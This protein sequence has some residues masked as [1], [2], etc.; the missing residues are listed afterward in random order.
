RLEGL[1]TPDLLAGTVQDGT[2][3]G[4]ALAYEEALSL[5]RPAAPEADP[6]A[7]PLTKV[8]E[9]REL[10]RQREHT[11]ESGGAKVRFSRKGGITLI[12]RASEL[13][14]EHCVA[15]ED[16]TD[17][18]TLDGFVPREGERPR[19]FSPAFL[20]PV[21]ALHGAAGDRLVLR[22]RLGRG[23]RG[24]PCEIVLE[25]RRAERTV[26]MTVRI[27]NRLADHR[28]RIRFLSVPRALIAAEG[29]PG[30]EEVLAGHRRFVAATLVRACGKLLVGDEVVAVPGAQ[31]QGWIEHR[32]RL[33]TG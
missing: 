18:G 4:L 2:A 17:E 26:R 9:G 10:R 3:R 22:G 14:V 11:I 20:Q 27:E 19:L 32:F 12:D 29:T 28:L 30:F 7:D 6:L 13:M 33:G 31:V 15:F 21:Q 25:G 1:D 8:F 24:F 23:P 16:R 5:C